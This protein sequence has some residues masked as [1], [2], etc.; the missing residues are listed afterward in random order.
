MRIIV[1][2]KVLKHVAVL[3]N[4]HCIMVPLPSRICLIIIKQLKW[5]FLDGI[6]STKSFISGGTNCCVKARQEG[7]MCMWFNYSIYGVYD[8]CAAH[9][10]QY[11]AGKNIS[12][13]FKL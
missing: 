2:Q 8:M 11:Y 4:S 12:S 5:V 3:F 1:I 7:E 6:A 13:K 9:E 10:V